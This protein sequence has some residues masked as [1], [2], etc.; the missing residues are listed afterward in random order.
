MTT[1]KEV[2]RKRVAKEEE[3][4]PIVITEVFSLNFSDFFKGFL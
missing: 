1:L 4:S 3:Y 2:L